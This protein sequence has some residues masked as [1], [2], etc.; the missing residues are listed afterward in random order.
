MVG[1]RACRRTLFTH[2]LP[3]IIP[4]VR[5]EI[6]Q[7][8]KKLVARLQE[9]L[10]S[11]ACLRDYQ[12]SCVQR[13]FDAEVEQIE[14]EFE[15]EKGQLKERLLADL[16]EHRR[17]LLEKRELAADDANGGTDICISGC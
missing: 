10:W 2:T 17:R 1:S 13:A 8:R 7:A 3:S 9:Q 6:A 14:R 5:E 4:E 12:L 11:A 16:M 15:A